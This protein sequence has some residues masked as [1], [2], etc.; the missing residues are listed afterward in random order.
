MNFLSWIPVCAGCLG[1]HQSSNVCPMT[2]QKIC[3]HYAQ[4]VCSIKLTGW[5]AFEVNDLF[6][7][8]CRYFYCFKLFHAANICLNSVAVYLLGLLWEM[9]IYYR[10]YNWI[11][12]S[13]AFS[14]GLVYWWHV[15]N[16]HWHFEKKHQLM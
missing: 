16:I 15:Y 12:V 10:L 9:S 2:S 14:F 3:L 5:A 8:P 4:C 11:G 7:G 6:Y 1:S 13:H